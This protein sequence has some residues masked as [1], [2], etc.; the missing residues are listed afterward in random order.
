MCKCFTIFYNHT[1]NKDLRKFFT[2][3]LNLSF[4]LF[5]T[6]KNTTSFKEN[7]IFLFSIYSSQLSPFGPFKGRYQLLQKLRTLNFI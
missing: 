6:G 3:F 5:Y 2:M 7:Y 1:T 4:C